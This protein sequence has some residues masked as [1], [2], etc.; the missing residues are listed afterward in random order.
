SGEN[1]T[2]D[3]SGHVNITVEGVLIYQDHLAN[4]MVV[5]GTNNTINIDGGINVAGD[6]SAHIIDGISIIGDNTVNISGHSTMD[7]RQVV[8]AFT[9][10]TV[11]DGG[12]VIFDKNSVTDIS[13]KV[14]DT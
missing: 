12:N 4:G 7:I 1:N 14:R 11:A 10:V 9:L 13:S 2:V 6:S 8:G 5:S 3:I